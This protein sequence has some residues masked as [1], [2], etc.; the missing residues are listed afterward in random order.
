[1]KNKDYIYAVCLVLVHFSL[2]YYFAYIKY[3]G[4]D[5][6]EYNYILGMPEWFFYSTIVVS[7]FV[8]VLLFFVCNILFNRD[9]E[10]EE[11]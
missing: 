4:I 6:S 10:E 5:P 9:I 3:K 1:M 2:W 11:S 7:I 8:I